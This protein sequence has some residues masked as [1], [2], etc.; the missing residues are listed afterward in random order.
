MQSKFSKKL[1][2]IK[3][4]WQTSITDE[5]IRSSWE[6]TGFKLTLENGIVKKYEF[7]DS[8]KEKIH[9]I[10]SHAEITSNE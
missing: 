5:L 4:A 6:A 9:Q 8:F 7:L 1:L 3:S 10:V 2:K